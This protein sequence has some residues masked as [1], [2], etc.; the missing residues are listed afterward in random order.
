M[1]LS[2]L[3]CFFLGVAVGILALGFILIGIAYAIYK[4]SK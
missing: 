1:Y 3:G 4:R 2:P